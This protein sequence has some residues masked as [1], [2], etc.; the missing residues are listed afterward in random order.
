VAN[1]IEGK[2][3]PEFVGDQSKFKYLAI[4]GYEK[5]QRDKNGSLGDGSRLW[6]KDA[7]RKDSDHEYSSL[8]VFQRYVLDGMRRLTGLHGKWPNNDPLWVVRGLCIGRKERGPCAKA[9]RTLVELGLVTLS[10]D[11]LGS[12][13]VVEVVD[14]NTN[15]TVQSGT[16]Q[17]D[18]T[19]GDLETGS[20]A[21]PKA[22]PSVPK[23]EGKITVKPS[24]PP[25]PLSAEEQDS[26]EG[27]SGQWRFYKLPE[28]EADAPVWTELIRKHGGPVYEDLAIPNVM[29]WMMFINNDGYWK[30]RIHSV[31]DFARCYS[32]MHEQYLKCGGD[33]LKEALLAAGRKYADDLDTVPVVPIDDEWD[34]GARHVG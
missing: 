22:N 3:N 13:E 23:I 27:L 31:K 20:K 8:T 4:H 30:G 21:A 12:L 32:T 16:V 26:L 24:A 14:K 9:V 7:C 10:N 18:D 6:I 34:P 29:A 1:P 15:S 5:F 11:Q 33:E 2:N 25:T 17:S 19:D 28:S